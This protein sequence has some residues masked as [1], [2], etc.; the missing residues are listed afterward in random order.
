MVWC[1]GARASRSDDQLA[2]GQDTWP[3][4]WRGIHCARVR[5]SGRPSKRVVHLADVA[6][7]WRRPHARSAGSAPHTRRRRGRLMQGGAE[8]EAA[9][10]TGGLP[11]GGGGF[12]AVVLLLGGAAPCGRMERVRDANRLIG[13]P[14][15]WL[16]REHDLP[17]P[18]HCSQRRGQ[19]APRGEH[20]ARPHMLAGRDRAAI[21]GGRGRGRAALRGRAATALRGERWP[22]HVRG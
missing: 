13:G 9:H 2:P 10:S 22:Y 6:D 16:P 4:R 15:G 1:T 7:R 18:P 20:A 14:P 5:I 8:A 3:P 17:L 19:V 12:A 11:L 21:R